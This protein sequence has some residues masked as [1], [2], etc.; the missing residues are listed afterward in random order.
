VFTV[1]HVFNDLWRANPQVLGDLLFHTATEALRILLADSRWLGAEPGLT[2]TLETWNDRLFFHPHLHC[3]VTGGGLTPQGT[4]QDVP[5]PR[6]LVAVKP[7]MWEFRKRFCRAVKQA[8]EQDDLTLP[9]RTTSRQWLNRLNKA[10]RQ[11]WEVFIAKPPEDGGPTPEAILNYQAEDVAGGPLS[12]I[13]LAPAVP[14]LSAAQLGYL[15][16]VPLSETRLDEADND[17]VTF[18]WG[19]YNPTTGIRERTQTETIPVAEFLRRYLQHVPP[20]HYQT[21]RHYGLYTSAKKVAYER[22]CTLLADRQPSRPLSASEDD[23]TD[24]TV[25][26]QQHTCPVCGQPLIVSGY[27]PSSVTGRIIPRLPLGHIFARP[28]T[29]GGGP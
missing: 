6:C 27:L 14:D 29:G 7:L 10:N 4:W 3:L 1:S 9:E 18:R 28:P 26:I 15:K 5:N 24:D 16:S 12:A 11:P 22:C 13:R 25:W 17:Q 20:P 21:V 8:I 23:Q 19:A 2:V